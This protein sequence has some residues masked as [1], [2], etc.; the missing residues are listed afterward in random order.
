M[1][2]QAFFFDM[3]RCS[4]CKTCELACKDARDL[5]VGTTYRRVYEYAGGE[6]TKDAQGCCSSTCF[7]CSVALSCCHCDD[8]ACVKV[9]PTAAM[10]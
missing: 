3:T 6:T 5:K 8:P 9:C 2:Q 7:G 1:A 10:H 4:G